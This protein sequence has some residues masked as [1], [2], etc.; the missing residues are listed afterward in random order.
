M[1][2]CIKGFF[3]FL[4]CFRPLVLLN[5]YKSHA[6]ISFCS[7]ITIATTTISGITWLCKRWSILTILF[8][9]V[10]IALSLLIT[11]KASNCCR[12]MPT[13]LYNLSHIIHE[14]S[15]G[16][17]FESNKCI[18]L[19]KYMHVCVHAY[20]ILFVHNVV[21][22]HC[23]SNLFNLR[24]S[25][26]FALSSIFFWSLVKMDNWGPRSYLHTQPVVVTQHQMSIFAIE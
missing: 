8:P 4:I 5:F 16:F 1:N 20:Y 21:S 3:W 14:G 23:S 17:K 22:I 6:N 2:T 19:R 11:R 12:S 13:H 18:S 15:P 10:W 26:S 24:T 25:V 9:Q 7:T